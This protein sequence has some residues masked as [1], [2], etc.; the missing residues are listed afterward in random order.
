[1][2]RDLD[3]R[4]RI[5]ADVSGRAQVA[6]LGESVR[7]LGDG[8]SEAGAE[9]P[10]LADELGRASEAARA[11]QAELDQLNIDALADDIERVGI[12]NFIAELDRLA[13]QGGEMAPRFAE[14]ARELRGLQ[15]QASTGAGAM[16]QLG[17]GAREARRDIESV[18]DASDVLGTKLKRLAGALGGVF[19]VSK[20]KG[21]AGDA[22]AVADSYGQMASRIEMATE[23]A[24]E[25]DLVQ[26]R[27]LETAS[28]TY[29]PLEEAQELYIRTA[30]ALRSLGYETQQA[31]D[32]TD[33][34]S[35]LLVTNA[36]S[37]EAAASAIGAYSKAIQTGR[38]TSQEWVSIQA[39]M[40]SLVDALAQAT[41][42]SAEEI[43]RLGVTGKLA[44]DDLNEG[45][46]R[47]VEANKAVAASMPTTVADAVQS[48]ANAWS[49]YIGEANRA[50]GT[51]ERLAEMIGTVAENL[52]TVVAMSM[53]AGQL[54]VAAFAV[55]A[56]MAVKAYAAA[57]LASAAA[58][59]A[60]TR[61][62]TAYGAAAMAATAQVTGLNVALAVKARTLGVIA[63]AGRGAVA[64]LA[65]IT[66]WT[67]RATVAIWAKVRALGAL[68]L[69]MI[70][71]GV[72]ALVV[73]LGELIA[74][75]TAGRKE[76][77]VLADRVEQVFT[78][79]PDTVTP[80][81]EAL[82]LRLGELRGNAEALA[83]ALDGALN[84]ADLG[85]V[86]GIEAL[87]LDLN[88]VQNAAEAT[89]E[90]IETALR[91][92][93]QGLNAS[94][95][96]AFGIMSE[97]AFNRGKVGARQL[98][99]ALDAQAGE[100]LRR[101]GVDA[102]RVLTGMSKRFGEQVGA[103][104]VLLGQVERLRAVGV[105]TG[106]ALDEAFRGALAGA[107]AGREFERLGDLITDAGRRGQVTREQLE[108]M[109]DAVRG[110]AREVG[111][112]VRKITD[113]IEA[114]QKR[115]ADVRAGL[116]GAG[117]RAQ[118]RRDRGL[119]DE[120]R[121]GVMARRAREALREAER[122]TTAA[123]NAV[124]DGRTDAAERGAKAA[125]EA[126]ERAVAA[127]DQ[128]KDDDTAVRLLERI[129]SAEARGLDAQA[130]LRK[131]Q[132]AEMQE[133][134]AARA[135]ALNELEQRIAKLAEGAVVVVRPDTEAAEQALAAVQAAVE[136]IP[137]EKTI[138][139]RTV[140]VGGAGATGGARDGGGSVERTIMDAARI[141]GSRR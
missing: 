113:A 28:A 115:A 4:L 69:A 126:I 122:L 102:D 38:V 26:R 78:A 135:A 100:A 139:V 99:Q 14:A 94:E 32:I 52:D 56:V 141:V 118:E 47:S 30:G 73:G 59:G 103:L 127:A 6:D 93:L 77:E 111:A 85:S 74:R 3:T 128:I 101:L 121:E 86:E 8:A 108:G 125:A 64:P 41:G 7:D 39:A 48:L 16:G 82:G 13:A 5:R 2:S 63:A 72:G 61:A 45:L 62:T 54:I 87:L 11:A 68:R 42:K 81:V 112:E 116:A 129:A 137:S 109:L 36:A 44:L 50:N 25:Y 65:L 117:A 89:G 37:A 53:K 79:P 124:W 15:A 18:G 83:E 119:S 130:Q 71:T 84:K 35:Y 90:Q 91:K 134:S 1:M 132:A 34:F 40:P 55:R 95:L 12:G 106:R 140:Q 138:F 51:T 24:A 105:D 22:I 23:S 9:L 96:R 80:Q 120:D 92:R 31:L 76:A 46:R 67:S 136:A 75:M 43:R 29:R 19:A 104:D 33:S 97:M 21:Y 20:L 88:D 10:S 70:S 131:R 66:A 133:E 98:G 107:E 49:A 123:A 58:S 27:L 60:A 57:L 114:L 17:A 110:R